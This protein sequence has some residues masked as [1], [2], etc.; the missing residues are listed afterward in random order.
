MKGEF[1]IKADPHIGFLH[2]GTEKLIE[3]KMFSL[4]LPYM[5]RLD[6]VSTVSQEHVFALSLEKNLKIMIPIRAKYIRVILCE[7]AR[8]LNHLLAIG[9]HI[10][11]IGAITPFMWFF[12]E[13]EKILE[14]FERIS[15][16]RFHMNFIR[17]GGVAFDLPFGI[18][19][20]IY[21]FCKQF[22]IRLNELSEL[23]NNNRIWKQRLVDIG[24]VKYRQAKLFGFSGVLLRGSGF[25][26]DLRKTQ[27]YENYQNFKFKVICGKNGDC[28]DR[29]L[30]RFGE[31]KQS[32]RI[33]V[34]ALNLITKGPFKALNSTY[35]TP[36]RSEIKR[37]MES[38]II[39]YKL[40]SENFILENEKIGYIAT[41]A[42]KGEFGLYFMTDKSNTFY[43]CKIKAPSFNHLQAIHHMSAHLLLADVV[44]IIGTQDIV[45]GEID[46]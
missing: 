25:S 41:E 18:I 19:C 34:S 33:I 44:A 9:C 27:P 36:F 17:P 2:R 13:R 46:R 23:L 10:M 12:E 6:Y 42:P 43:R 26:W 31:M 45:F 14:F 24:I 39:H 38:L 7:L 21:D 4:A 11:D 28:F 32:L 8:I 35:V 30:I 22:I 29:Y 5:D 37:N 15:G 1:I 3:N 16:A 20:D 40:Y